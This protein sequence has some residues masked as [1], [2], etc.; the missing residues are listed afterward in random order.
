MHV[1]PPNPTTLLDQ[2]LSSLPQQRIDPDGE[3]RLIARQPL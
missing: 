2:T 3:R 1:L